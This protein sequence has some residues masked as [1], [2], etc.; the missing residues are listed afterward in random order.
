[1]AKFPGVHELSM[2]L[3]CEA[4]RSNLRKTLKSFWESW[5]KKTLKEKK[6]SGAATREKKKLGLL[7]IVERRAVENKAGESCLPV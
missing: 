2:C 5:V 1:M 3:H 4:P 7:S 6:I